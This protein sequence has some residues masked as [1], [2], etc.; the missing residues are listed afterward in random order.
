VSKES[1]GQP[2]DFRQRL[3]PVQVSAFTFTGFPGGTSE[4]HGA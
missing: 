4:T 1:A 2:M 3:H